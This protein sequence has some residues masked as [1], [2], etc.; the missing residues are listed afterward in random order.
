LAQT[1]YAE[2]LNEVDRFAKKEVRPLALEEDLKSDHEAGALLW[3]KSS[4]LDL[5]VLLIPEAFG[6]AGMDLMVGGLMLDRL[7]G[8]CAGFAS[9]CL[10]HFT[11][12]AAVSSCGK[13]ALEK[14]FSAF[15]GKDADRPVLA[16]VCF[17]P[18][19]EDVPVLASL[20]KNSLVI[21]G[22]TLPMGNAGLAKAVI[23][24]AHMD[25]NRNEPAAVLIDPFASGVNVENPLLL[26]GLKIN[27]FARLCFQNVQVEGSAVLATG[28]EAKK[29][30]RTAE[31]AFY[32]FVSAMA[33]GCARSAFQKAKDYAMQRY[34]FKNQIIFHQEIQRMLGNMKMKL[35]MGTAGYLDL[36]DGQKWRPAFHAPDAALVKAFCTDAALEIVLDAIQI[37]GG[38]GY[39]HEYGIEKSMRDIKVLQ[40]LGD[41][42]PYLLVRHIADGLQ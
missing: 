27:P 9:I 36:L 15:P 28:E 20:E 7:A 34:Q 6:G 29:M 39:M 38:Y 22:S 11:A 1:I 33:M 3:Q 12:C 35:D 8:E 13:A 32:G 24:F 25:E 37:H 30:M 21:N 23:L 19:P 4:G 18:E 31:H 17:S 26:P 41:T 2:I 10:H 40:V 16:S 14:W 5:P 42:N